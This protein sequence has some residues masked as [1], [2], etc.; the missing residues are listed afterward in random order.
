MKFNWSGFHKELVSQLT[1]EDVRWTCE[2]LSRLS[3]EQWRDAFRAGGYDPQIA[4]RYIA[5]FK[6][7]I[8]EGLALK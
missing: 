3:D 6:Q 2:R 1:P 7:K 4:R 8:A 5:R